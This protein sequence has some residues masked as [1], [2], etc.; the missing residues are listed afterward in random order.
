MKKILFTLTLLIASLSIKAQ[1][2]ESLKEL[3]IE[4]IRT[5]NVNDETIIA[6]EDNVYRGT[7][8]GIG[9]VISTALNGIAKDR[10][11]QLV[12][13]DN[14]IPQL[15]ITLPI[16]LVN[17]F[18]EGKISIT[19][20]YRQ[21]GMSCDTEEAMKKL[22]K[23]HKVINSSAGK[24]DLVIYPEV[25]LENSGFK[26]LY[27]YYVNLA[28]AVEM[29]L[30]KG[31]ELTAQVVFPVATNLHGQYGKIRPGVMTLAQEFYF[32]KSFLGR[33]V[34]GNFTDN[35]MGA[36]AELRWRSTTGR[37]ELDALAGTTVQSILTDEDG[38]YIS[39][40]VRVNAA[41]KASYY[42][43]HYNLQFDLQ[44]S[45]YMYGDIGI[46]GDCTRHFGDYSI[47]VYG[48]YT[49]GEV[50]GG[51]HFA[52]PLPGK[53][54][55]RNRGI[56]VRQADFFSMEYSMRSWGK[57]V[58]NHLA[59]TYKT[60]PGENRSSRFF[61]PDFIRYFLVKEAEKNNESKAVK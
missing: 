13:L 39:R 37:Y 26:E 42:E 61:N 16:N 44:A 15:C 49:D 25:K 1:I 18:K 10:E 6:F 22:K 33:V 9:K 21:M 8:R 60:R 29:A 24:V 31:A 59:E 11:L 38:W 40:K 12:V 5:A 30:W 55:S 27:T 56:R 48:L 35:R 47:G 36:Q 58:D 52:I 19:E 20:I 7:Y 4:N 45:R 43:P 14:N 57:Y 54:W 28:P 51:F 53:K 17:G 34:A 2:A 50:N 3:G 23:S 41:V 46:R 32:G